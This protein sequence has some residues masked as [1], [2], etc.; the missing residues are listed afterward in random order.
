MH[1]IRVLL[2]RVNH[3]IEYRHLSTL[4]TGKTN[5]MA[6]ANIANKDDALKCIA[7]AEKYWREGK[8]FK[9]QYAITLSP[10][11]RKQ[12]ESHKIV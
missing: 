10:T 6:P 7:L 1:I 9:I 11:I 3:I 8:L 2:S 12:R 5:N 4:H